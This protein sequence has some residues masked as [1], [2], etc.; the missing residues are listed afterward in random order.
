LEALKNLPA[1]GFFR[2]TTAPL[3]DPACR[4]AKAEDRSCKLFD[5]D[6]LIS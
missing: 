3:T 5:G 1:G 6:G 4:L 2:F